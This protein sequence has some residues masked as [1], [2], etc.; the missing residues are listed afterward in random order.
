[1]QMEPVQDSYV[2]IRRSFH[3]RSRA[4]RRLLHSLNLLCLGGDQLGVIVY[5]TNWRS[6][7]NSATVTLLRIHPDQYYRTLRSHR[8]S[9][10]V[11]GIFPYDLTYVQ[12]STYVQPHTKHT[13]RLM[14]SNMPRAISQITVHAMCGMLS[15]I[16]TEVI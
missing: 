14:A 13:F 5:D 6:C 15:H 16:S 4:L 12:K 2:N 7:T 10:E 8:I 9:Y 11:G 1:M 3:R